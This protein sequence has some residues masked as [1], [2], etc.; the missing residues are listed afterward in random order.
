MDNNIN[1]QVKLITIDQLHDSLMTFNK[2]SIELKKLCVGLITGIP[3]ILYKID[4]NAIKSEHAII[5]LIMVIGFL[6]LDSHYHYNQKKIRSAMNNIKT[7][8]SEGSEG[9]AVENLKW[10][11]SVL[12]FSNI[13][14]FFLIIVCFYYIVCLK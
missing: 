9:I 1:Q 4:G 8:L 11:K 14:Y 2:N 10:Y 3:A 5:L 12:N 13:L 6:V 7:A